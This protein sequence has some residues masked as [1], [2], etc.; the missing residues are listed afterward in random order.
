MDNI[1]NRIK[2][3]INSKA[4]TT[5]RFAEIIGVKQSTLSH[6]LN[7]RN[8]PSLDI[9]LSIS[10]TF[11]EISMDW[12]T[13][14]K[15]CMLSE[16]A[17]VR[18]DESQS[19]ETSDTLRNSGLDVS[20]F[21]LSEGLAFD[22]KGGNVSEDAMSSQHAEDSSADNGTHKSGEVD[23][24]VPWDIALNAGIPYEAV[25]QNLSSNASIFPTETAQA[26]KPRKITEVRIFFDDNT[27]ES[28]SPTLFDHPDN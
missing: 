11:P 9:L 28:F 5:A 19:T 26:P 21:G 1:C 15:G 2:E 25:F 3:I 8:K 22:N 27:F 13:K 23:R 18:Q 14:G 16:N 20:T 12:L 4:V 24:Q 7:G 10:T 17:S 6:T